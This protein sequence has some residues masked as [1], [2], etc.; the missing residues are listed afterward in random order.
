MASFSNPAF[1]DQIN[2]PKLFL[3]NPTQRMAPLLPPTAERGAEV[4][5]E[6][7]DMLTEAIELYG[8]VAPLLSE[9]LMKYWSAQP[10]EKIME[11]F[12]ITIE[13]GQF[14]LGK[15]DEA[16]Q[17]IDRLRDRAEALEKYRIAVKTRCA[18]YPCYC[19]AWKKGFMGDDVGS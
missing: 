15:R 8:G 6:G 12:Y 13:D 9:L 14:Y 2:F 5:K 17:E 18:K 1:Q 4:I 10:V 11:I 3:I 16:V 7:A 19:G